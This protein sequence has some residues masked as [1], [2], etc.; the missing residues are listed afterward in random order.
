MLLNDLISLKCLNRGSR[1]GSVVVLYTHIGE[2]TLDGEAL[3]FHESVAGAFSRAGFVVASGRRLLG[4]IQLL[5]IFNILRNT[6]ERCELCC[7]G[8]GQ[9]WE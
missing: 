2:L 7:G 9:A 8:K 1:Y 5:G 3:F 6:V 4:L